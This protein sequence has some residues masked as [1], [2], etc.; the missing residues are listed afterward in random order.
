MVL[1]YCLLAWCLRLSDFECAVVCV[2]KLNQGAVLQDLAGLLLD[3][4]ML[5]QDNDK[6]NLSLLRHRLAVINSLP[7]SSN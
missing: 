6:T 3:Y 2:E 1:V 4:A 7:S 5:Y